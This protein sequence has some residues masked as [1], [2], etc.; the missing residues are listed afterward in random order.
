M[1]AFV[2]PPQVDIV[3]NDTD[4]TVL[5]LPGEKTLRATQLSVSNQNPVA[6]RFRLWDTFTDSAG[7]VHSS[8]ADEVKL[9]DM[10]LQPGE[11]VELSNENG[12]FT[13]IGTIVAQSDIAAAA[14]SHIAVSLAGRL[15]P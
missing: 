2:S 4:V 7:V 10:E 9:R 5:V 8:T 6:V 14:P 15:E 11:T 13:A 3:A 1:G 12:L